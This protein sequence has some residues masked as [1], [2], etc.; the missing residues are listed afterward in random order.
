MSEILKQGKFNI[1]IIMQ[2]IERW[3]KLIKE[4]KMDASKLKPNVKAITNRKMF[5]K[6]EKQGVI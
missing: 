4:E 1:H 3:K 5:R 2:N 6:L